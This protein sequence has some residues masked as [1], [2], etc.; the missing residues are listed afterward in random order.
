M[1]FSTIP[2]AKARLLMMLQADAGLAGVFVERGM[3][4]DSPPQRERVYVDNAVDIHR[5]W[6]MVGRT[7]ITGLPKLAEEYTVRI[8]VEVYQDGNAQAACED[9]MWEVVA[10]IELAVMNNITL[11]GLL[12]GTSDRP[13]GAKPGDIEGQNSFA[14]NDGWF[15]QAVVRIDCGARI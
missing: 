2:Q 7:G 9:R 13:A 4:V 15:S 3:P 8:P 1:A 6:Q 5:E 12:N 10:V 11:G 14:Y